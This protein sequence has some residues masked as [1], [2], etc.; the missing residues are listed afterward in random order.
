MPMN[1][2]WV[3]YP[4]PAE[5]QAFIQLSNTFSA[6]HLRLI[7]LTG[8]TV[9]ERSFGDRRFVQLDL[10]DMASGIYLIEVTGMNGT[11]VQKLIVR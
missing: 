1:S 9:A 7:D 11:E 2:G 6:N 5:S 4:N 8:K 3:V 10:S